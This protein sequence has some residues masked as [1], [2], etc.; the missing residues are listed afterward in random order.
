[1]PLIHTT[2]RL[3]QGLR[4]LCSAHDTDACDHSIRRPGYISL[5]KPLL[6]MLRLAGPGISA[7][8]HAATW[9][10]KWLS[11]WS[12]R[13]SRV[14]FNRVGGDDSN[15]LDILNCVLWI[16]WGEFVRKPIAWYHFCVKYK[17]IYIWRQSD[18]NALRLNDVFSSHHFTM[19]FVPEM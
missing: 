9:P 10:W 4:T 8:S 12:A 18:A 2:C 16:L 3:Y 1:M 14:E 7:V 6:F 11:L 17:S 13:S 15:R 19:V 5:R